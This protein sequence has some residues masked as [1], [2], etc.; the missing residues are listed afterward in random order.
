MVHGAW[1]M[2][3]DS[4]KGGHRGFCFVT[5]LEEEVAAFV[6]KRQHEICGRT[7]AVERATP[8]EGAPPPAPSSAAYLPSAYAHAPSDPS[9]GASSGPRSPGGAAAA[10]AAAQG[11]YMAAAQQA[12]GQAPAPGAEYGQAAVSACL[13][14][15]F[16]VSAL[17]VVLC[18]HVIWLI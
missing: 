2:V 1:Y 10:A 15:C 9:L 8:Q 11:Y 6:A 18:Q 3:Q 4:A 13:G 16:A 7:V 12:Y 14:G 17:V 5:F